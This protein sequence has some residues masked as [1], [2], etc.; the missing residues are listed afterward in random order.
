[1]LKYKILYAAVFLAAAVAL[2]YVNTASA[3]LLLIMMLL[4]PLIVR[5]SLM[6]NAKNITL[7]CSMS[8]A[9]VVGRKAK[10]LTVTMENKSLIPMGSVELVVMYENHMFGTSREESIS[11]YGSG[12][13]QTFEIPLDTQRCGRSMIT[14]KEVRYCDVFNIMRSRIDFFWKKRYTV[15]PRLPELQLHTQKLLAAEFG[16]TNYD[17]TRRGNDNSEVFQ[18]RGYEP[19]DNLSA[20][21]WKLS[22]KT[23]DII[24]REWSRPK[25]FRMLIVFDPVSKDILGKD[26]S[27]DVLGGIIG[28]SSSVSRELIRQGMGH[29][30]AMIN[31]GIQIDVSINQSDDSDVMLDDIMSIVVPKENNDFISAML[32]LGLQSRYSKLV[33]IG[34]EAN[35]GMLSE[36]SAY[37]DVTAIGV[38]D[39]GDVL[40]SNDAGYEMYTLSAHEIAKKQH[41]I[42]L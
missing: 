32:A 18:V 40:Y 24:I 29:N 9:C 13:K 23:D 41:F 28:L 22:A 6:D 42:E 20:A 3:L 21:H 1:M 34:P 5:L 31:G 7:S 4:L 33:Y 17:R 37:M 8:E 38:R 11:L 10:P 36:L 30:I 19:G 26:I 27:M 15:Y 35:A 12:K 16:G 2:A 39:D 14:I 25:N